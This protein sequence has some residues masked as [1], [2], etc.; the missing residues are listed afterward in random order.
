MS[1]KNLPYI[2]QY[3]ADYGGCGFW[4]FL[5]PQLVMNMKGL[6]SVCHSQLYIRDFLH[7]KKA[8][9]VHI[10]RQTKP[11]QLTFF[12]KLSD[13]K[14]RMNF[15]LIYESDDIIFPEDIP[16]YN[17]AKEKYLSHTSHAKEIMELCDEVT[18]STPF[19]RDY[20][21]N[22]TNQKN[23]TVIPNYPPL[24]WI[25]SHFSEELILRNYRAH[26]SRP[27]ILYSGSASH[28]NFSTDDKEIPDD[29]S[30]VKEVILA[31][32]DKFKWVF[33]GAFPKS[34]M[35][36][37]KAGLVEYHP[38]QN[39]DNYPR[40]LSKLQIN[41]WIA[42]L[43]ENDFNRAKSDLK[44]LEATAFGLPVACQDLCTYAVAP[45]KFKTGEEMIKRI[46]ETLE[47]EETFLN[48]SRR[49]RTLLDGRWLERDENIGKYLDVYCHPYGHPM[50][51]YV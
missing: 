44:F 16:P 28:F 2:I 26:K 21:L 37:I 43:Q 18:V 7:Y 17:Q 40:F 29:F 13:V 10:Q 8:T 45:I 38:W 23:I 32:A 48:A 25:G 6:A 42:P 15:R 35:Q 20:Y 4:R 36:F 11:M 49:A 30:H 27:R 12:Q 47:T 46:R 31:N 39:L 9:A 19:L 51:K 3:P 50:R 24:F 33:V 5:W 22:K 14:K 41:M 1:E 34:L